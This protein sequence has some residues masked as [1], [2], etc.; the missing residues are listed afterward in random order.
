MSLLDIM[1]DQALANR[2]ELASLRIV[3]EKEILHL[4]VL[5][6]LADSGFLKGLVFIG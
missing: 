3:V 2:P 5:R 1:V 4:D 6:V